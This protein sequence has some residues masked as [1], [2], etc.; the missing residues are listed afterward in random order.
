MRITRGI[1]DWCITRAEQALTNSISRGCYTEFSSIVLPLVYLNRVLAI[2][3][4]RDPDS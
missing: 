1:W 4:S 2:I 3:R